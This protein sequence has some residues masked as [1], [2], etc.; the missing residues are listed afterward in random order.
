MLDSCNFSFPLPLRLR[1]RI[2]LLTGKLVYF[3]LQPRNLRTQ[4][5]LLRLKF[6]LEPQVQLILL[7]KCR[8]GIL[9][10]HV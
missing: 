4:T 9:G 5:R 6:L 8:L 1:H 3:R 7:Q 10:Q 2:F